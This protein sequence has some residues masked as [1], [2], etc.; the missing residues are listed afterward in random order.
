MIGAQGLGAQ[1]L[2]GIARLEI[3]RGFIA[4]ISIVF[5]AI[6]LDRISQKLTKKPETRSVV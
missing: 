3:G 1:V 2:E 6:I 5:T 4:G